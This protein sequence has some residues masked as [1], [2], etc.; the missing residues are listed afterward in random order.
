MTV[1]AGKRTIQAPGKGRVA[2]A[3]V[4]IPAARSVSLAVYAAAALSL[5]AAGAHLWA[6]P[7][8][9][10]MWWGYGAFF[11]AVAL[12]QGICAVLLLRW[13]AAPVCFA[14]I[15][16][17]LSVVTLYIV[18]RTSGVPFG[19]HAGKMEGAGLLDMAATA[20]ELGIVLALVTLLGG[21]ARQRT[22]NALL[23][24][25]AVLWAARIAGL[26]S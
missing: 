12:A 15:W 22:V 16:G 3:N 20:A 6:F 10:L 8:H 26:L 4:T 1:E 19:P 18:T 14:G 2:A 24:L 5:A 9:L 13:P 17:N 21:V 7:E 11:L 25:G 23:L